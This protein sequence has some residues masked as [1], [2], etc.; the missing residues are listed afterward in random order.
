MKAFLIFSL[1]I[2][3]YFV[4]AQDYKKNLGAIS[5]SIST[6]DGQAAPYVSVLIK[7]AGQGTITDEKGNFEIKKVKPGI[8]ILNVSLSG[9]IDSAI[10]I[11][12]KQNETFFL[13][14]QLRETYAA[15]KTII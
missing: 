4:S 9:Y 14:I 7:N 11:E 1:L 12:I 2:S 15:L 5:G 3:F 8:Y 10:N 13:K 6:A